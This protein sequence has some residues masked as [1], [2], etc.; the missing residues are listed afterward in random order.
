M[1][2]T[3]IQ[4]DAADPP[5]HAATV[6]ADLGHELKVI[7]LDRGDGIP[8]VAD[9]D[10][11]MTFGGAISLTTSE[12]PEW[13]IQEQSLI[14]KYAES[15]R[16]VLGICL[17]SQMVAAAL[18][19]TVRRNEQ[20]E[21][22]W[23]TVDHVAESTSAIGELFRDS[24]TVFHWHQDTFGIPDGAQHILR[25]AATHHQG[26]TIDDRIVGLQFHLE[27]NKKTVETFLFVSQ[28]WRQNAPHV[29]SEQAIREGIET[30][31]RGQQQLLRSLLDQMKQA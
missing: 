1:K 9:A 30:Y 12:Q 6:A 27:A 14:R 11:L 21:A 23:H 8:T 13:V 18:G 28:L 3:A 29:Q 17:G 10:M 7:R 31:L 25:S 15:G 22:G 20:P 5:A 4:H 2:I 16:R 19:A 26:F 24:P